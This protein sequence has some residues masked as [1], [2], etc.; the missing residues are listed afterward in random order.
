MRFLAGMFLFF[1]AI[2]CFAAWM[3][4]IGAAVL[5]RF[6]T[7]DSWA[8]KPVAPPP[9]PPAAELE[10]PAAPPASEQ[11]PEPEP[12]DDAPWEPEVESEEERE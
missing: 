6:G 9:A 10:A 5:T 2:V 11:T 7:A 1:G 3:I 8:R 12:P 4:G